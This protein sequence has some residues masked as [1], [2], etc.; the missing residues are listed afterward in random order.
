MRCTSNRSPIPDVE[1]ADRGSDSTALAVTVDVVDQGGSALGD[2][3]D[4]HTSLQAATFL[5][6]TAPLCETLLPSWVVRD[7]P[8]LSKLIG[9]LF[10]VSR[11]WEID[12]L[13]AL[14]IP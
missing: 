6:C 14:S 2:L 8:P 11:E 12:A 1:A 5:G 10:I 7:I 4:F 9:L 13:A 3:R